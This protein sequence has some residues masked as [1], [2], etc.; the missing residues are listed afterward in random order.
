[1]AQRVALLAI[2]IALVGM[3]PQPIAAQPAAQTS[4]CATAVTAAVAQVGKAYV[5]GA[6]GPNT[7]DCSGLTNWAWGQAGYGIGLSTYDQLSAGQPTG[8]SLSN[9]G[10]WQQGDLIFL[11]YPGG[12]HVSMYVG[13][14]LFADAY[15]GATGVIL[16]N[17]ADDSFYQTHFYT[18]RRIVSCTGAVSVPSG[19]SPI[20]LPLA[21]T[22]EMGA[23]PPLLGYVSFAIPQLASAIPQ[24]Q[25]VANSDWD[26]GYVFRWLGWNIGELGRQIMWFI[27]GIAQAGANLGATT[28]NIGV[29]GV[30]GIWRL[31]SFIWLQIR[32][33]IYGAWMLLESVRAIGDSVMMGIASIAAWFSTGWIIVTDVLALAGQ[34]FTQIGGLL[35]IVI[36][37]LSWVAAQASV[38]YGL[39]FGA[40]TATTVPEQLGGAGVASGGVSDTIYHAIRG[41]CEGVVESQLNWIMVVLWG[42]CWLAFIFWLAKFF[43]RGTANG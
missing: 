27:Q 4:P 31:G 37:I 18:A 25:P 12:Q 32:T 38:G 6:K 29:D 33:A 19:S 14:G 16:H 5:W 3:I 21:D 30:N 35:W 40:L 2:C 7:F 15:N 39:I 23:I 36:G 34:W 10:C 11:R 43:T 42:L 24:T 20:G 13:N 22:P 8:C 9:M 1:M 41:L 28:V 17:A 26:A